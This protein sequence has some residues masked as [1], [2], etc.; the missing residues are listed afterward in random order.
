M[1]VVRFFRAFV[2]GQLGAVGTDSIGTASIHVLWMCKGDLLSISFFF[3]S[4]IG[5]FGS[6][7]YCLCV[8]AQL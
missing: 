3:F 7:E 1:F 4:R 5:A 8:Y 2:C 6:T